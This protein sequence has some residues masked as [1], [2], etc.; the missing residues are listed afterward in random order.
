MSCDQLV[1][2]PLSVGRNPINGH[3]YSDIAIRIM[4][5]QS[6]LAPQSAG[7]GAMQSRTST[8][9]FRGLF[10]CVLLLPLLLS[11]LYVDNASSAR[12]QQGTL[13][14]LP[15]GAHF[16]Q[17]FYTVSMQM[18]EP[19]MRNV[20]LETPGQVDSARVLADLRQLTGEVPIC[21]ESGCHT[22]VNRKTGSQELAW[23]K[24][25]IRKELTGL[26]YLVEL[27]GWSGAG[28]TD[29]NLIVR[30]RGTSLPNEEV[31]FVAHLDGVKYVGES[32]FP[33]AD[34]DASGVV[35]LLE[36]A[37][38]LATHSF[39]RTVVLFFSTGEEEGRLGVS[40]YLNHLTPVELSSIKYVLNIDMVGYDSNRDWAMELWDGGHLPSHTLAQLISDTLRDQQSKL[41]PT[42]KVGCG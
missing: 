17:P 39:R 23:A 15:S 3:L 19:S 9:R 32:R 10:N 34:D 6:R 35:D 13:G 21:S 22:I 37:R 16:V 25:Y 24:D 42:L 27:F 11:A 5:L 33:A 8:L 36:L 7:G 40:S 30:K 31:Y 2:E 1:G 12:A 38:I 41:V 28:Y 26:G 20:A 29:Q 18:A 14:S 4:I